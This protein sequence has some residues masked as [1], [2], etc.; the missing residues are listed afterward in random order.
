VIQ[1]APSVARLTCE[2]DA[3]IIQGIDRYRSK[4]QNFP[5][6]ANS[7]SVSNDFFKTRDAPDLP[8]TSPSKFLCVAPSSRRPLNMMT[9]V[10]RVSGVF[11]SLDNKYVA[12]PLGIA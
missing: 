11:R 5:S 3:R 6:A 9:G 7:S 1:K 8:D 10:S 2:A 4:A 12:S